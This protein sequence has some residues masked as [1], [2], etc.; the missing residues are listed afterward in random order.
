MSS[1]FRLLRRYQ[2]GNEWSFGPMEDHYVRPWGDCHPD[3]YQIPI[4]NPD[5][6]KICVRKNPQ[7][8]NSIGT[9]PATHDPESITSP[10]PPPSAI[11]THAAENTPQYNKFTADLYNPTRRVA[12]QMYN[13]YP[14]YARRAPD[15]EYNLSNDVIRAA[16][17][18]N[19]TGLDPT[20]TPGT[21][22]GDGPFFEYGLDH[23]SV[24]PP[25]WDGT[26]LHQR[27]PIWESRHNYL[28]AGLMHDANLQ[29]EYELLHG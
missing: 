10:P 15:E 29:R 26:Q 27:R 19:G 8:V 20:R 13:P 2:E 21:V 17:R 22:P 11:S 23:V 16:I 5:G 3:F 14:Y 18:F 28:H 1:S 7:Y 9:T 24:P 25:H 6:V 12:D 4:G